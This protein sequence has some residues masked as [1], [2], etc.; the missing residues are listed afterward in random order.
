MLLCIYAQHCYTLCT[1]LSVYLFSSSQKGDCPLSFKGKSK[2][3][4]LPQE[5]A[6][7]TDVSRWL[8]FC[9]FSEI[10]PS[11]FGRRQCGTLEGKQAAY[12]KDVN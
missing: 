4:F 9:T 7:L 12:A 6:L 8:A 2:Q 1:T 5:I 3:V 11:A 10:L